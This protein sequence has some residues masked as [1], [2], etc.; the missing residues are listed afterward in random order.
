MA[1][2]YVMILSVTDNHLRRARA[3]RPDNDEWASAMEA[4]PAG[5]TMESFLRACLRRLHREPEAFAE[6][7]APD[8]P[9]ERRRG[10]PRK[11][12]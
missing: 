8:W 2:H 1:S 9:E 12:T 5:R 10:Q 6:H 7:L 4:L 3:F 11:A